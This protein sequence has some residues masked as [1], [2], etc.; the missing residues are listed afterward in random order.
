MTCF[1]S[2]NFHTDNHI[3]LKSYLAESHTR[4]SNG[5][6]GN[7]SVNA[8]ISVHDIDTDLIRQRHIDAESV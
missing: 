4:E 3:V 2:F 7:V 8:K 5:T 1:Q 6:M